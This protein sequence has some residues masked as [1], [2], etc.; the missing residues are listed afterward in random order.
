MTE[1]RLVV[2]FLWIKFQ[3]CG[4]NLGCDF[5]IRKK[6]MWILRLNQLRSTVLNEMT[7]VEH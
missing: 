6:K 5:T 3:C 2:L 4:I 7:L 1:I